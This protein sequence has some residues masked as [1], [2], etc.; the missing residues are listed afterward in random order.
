MD[1]ID[2]W[3]SYCLCPFD[4]PADLSAPCTASSPLVTIL[5]HNPAANPHTD[6]IPQR[7]T[8][9]D[10]HAR[11]DSDGLSAPARRLHPD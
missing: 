4:Q 8:S 6:A 10:G 1:G 7:N 3:Y 5:D 9:S 11:T 2:S